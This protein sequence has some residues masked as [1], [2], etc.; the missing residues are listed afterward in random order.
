[1][2]LCYVAVGLA[3]YE[4]YVILAF[5]DGGSDRS[6]GGKWS[7]A[8]MNWSITR[9]RVKIATDFIAAA[10]GERVASAVV[11]ADAGASTETIVQVFV[12]YGASLCQI[13]K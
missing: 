2:R 6:R 1:M 12:E 9:T 10:L 3:I 7:A 13:S 4:S 5:R 8:S 11:D